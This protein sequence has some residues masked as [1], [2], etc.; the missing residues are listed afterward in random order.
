M[1]TKN[2][3]EYLIIVDGAF[4]YT[5]FDQKHITIVPSSEDTLFKMFQQIILSFL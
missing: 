3:W 5:G 4:V 1:L 2:K